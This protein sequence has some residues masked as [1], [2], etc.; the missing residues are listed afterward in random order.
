VSWEYDGPL[1]EPVWRLL[2]AMGAAPALAHGLDRL[3]ELTGI[4]EAWNPLYPYLYPQLLAKALLGAGMLAAVLRSLR[5]RD[6]VTATG[7]LFGALLL[8]S[9]TVY[10]WYL[11]WVLPWAALAR[12]TAWLVLSGLILLSYLPKIAGVPL[13]PW[14]FLAIWV[15]FGVLMVAGKGWGPRA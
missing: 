6:P 7:R 5:E 8:L 11:L 15:P 14:V 2:D 3:K 4:W 10:P 12:Q 1:F 9:A 13:M